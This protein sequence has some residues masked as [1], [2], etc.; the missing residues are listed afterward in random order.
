[1]D[2]LTIGL[3]IIGVIGSLAA[4]FPIPYRQSIQIVAAVCLVFVVFQLGQQHERQ[5][6][7]LKVAQLN[8]QIAKLET[9]SQKVTTQVVTEYVDRVKIVKEKA[10]A[11][12]VKVPVYVN[13]SADN[14]CTINNGFV[15]LHDAA[16]KNK[17][18]ETPRDSHAGA[19]G[20]KLSTVASTVAGNYGTCHEIRQQLESLQ[21]WVRE[22]EK[23]INKG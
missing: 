6:W 10:D 4:L 21:K 23:I 1:V 19:S 5:E 8:E 3:G 18:P 15:V 11:I 13:Q 2:L 17:V 9:E 14:S 16:A 12:I 22:Q 7:E 20:V